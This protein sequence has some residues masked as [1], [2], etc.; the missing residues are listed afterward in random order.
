LENFWKS[1]A[2]CFLTAYLL[3]SRK[4]FIEEKGGLSE[5]K[6]E[7]FLKHG[8]LLNQFILRSQRDPGFYSYLCQKISQD[9]KTI[10][11]TKKCV[12]QLY[13]SMNDDINKNLFQIC[14]DLPPR[15]N[16]EN[17]GNNPRSGFPVLNYKKISPDLQQQMHFLHKRYDHAII[18]EDR[19]EIQ[20]IKSIVEE[21]R[22]KNCSFWTV[23]DDE[24]FYFETSSSNRRKFFSLRYLFANLLR[25]DYFKFTPHPD[26][27]FS[28]G[29]IDFTFLTQTIIPMMEELGFDNDLKKAN[30]D[31]AYLA[32]DIKKIAFII[33]FKDLNEEKKL[34]ILNDIY[35]L[36]INPAVI[37]S[38]TDLF[39]IENFFSDI[40]KLIKDGYY[41]LS[42]KYLSHVLELSRKKEDYEACFRSL[43]LLGSIEDKKN[44]WA[45][46]RDFYFDAY[47]I[48]E[49]ANRV[50][51]DDA[52]LF[53]KGYC[54]IRI[55]TATSLLGDKETSE[56]FYLKFFQNM[57]DTSLLDRVLLNKE[58]IK[59][60]H[61]TKQ[62]EK[63]YQLIKQ[64][65]DFFLKVDH[66]EFQKFEGQRKYLDQF[67]NPKKIGTFKSEEI[68]AREKS[69]EYELCFIMGMKFLLI[70]QYDLA[71]YWLNRGYEIQPNN[72]VLRRLA[73][74][75]FYRNNFPR[76]KELCEQILL[77][78]SED[79]FAFK[80]LAVVNYYSGDF[81]T[82][83]ENF[84]RA[85]NCASTN[86]ITYPF[87][88]LLLEYNQH[89]KKEN[90]YVAIQSI[91]RVFVKE[92]L[93]AK[94]NTQLLE[95][96]SDISQDTTIKIEPLVYWA[97]LGEDFSDL[98][99]LEEGLVCYKK[100]LEG[101]QF[102]DFSARVCNKIGHNLLNQDLI[103][104]GIRYFQKSTEFEPSAFFYFA[105]LADA[106]ANNLEYRSAVTNLDRAIS[107]CN[108]E[109]ETDIISNL[110]RS[111][112]QYQELA[113]TTIDF[114]KIKKDPDVFKTL[115]SAEQ[116][117]LKQ[118]K[119]I[120]KPEQFDF[121]VAIIPYAKAIE[122]LLDTHITEP[123]KLKIKSRKY[124][125]NRCGGIK[126]GYW[127]GGNLR[128][129]Y[130]SPLPYPL[131]S[132]LSSRAKKNKTM[133]LGS[134][135]NLKT[136]IYDAASNPIVKD[137]IQI[138]ENKID[139]SDF[140]KMGYAC[141]I[142]AE[143][144]NEI[145]HGKVKTWEEVIQIRKEIVEKINFII[146]LFV[147]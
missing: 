111:K 147:K 36:K 16:I 58:L 98:G 31:S 15:K 42:S 104:E 86:V 59:H 85:I 46:S 135:L 75:A 18:N 97:L 113:V 25:Y 78:D 137:F 48:L 35:P 29:F 30:V 51:V 45:R 47:E 10:W 124:I 95:I 122:I 76:V 126:D 8:G 144:R 67:R 14:P 28:L 70:F 33:W 6:I 128:K 101:S 81:K 125:F 108:P 50:R 23:F 24:E 82:S 117:V 91:V 141:N 88:D 71:E 114:S 112:T 65:S 26:D 143:Y 56:K 102:D 62:Y 80:T 132:V 37:E 116:L 20:T 34:G 21:I 57:Q 69:Q 54:Y 27:G 43:M 68:V 139:K 9:K 96:L 53:D 19:V 105:D 131:K 74:I 103:E 118:F 92:V 129:L 12:Q 110:R 66:N 41:D 106:Q 146:A 7:S 64:W 4:K 52:E 77:S 130:I 1:H 3:E 73:H 107:L 38:N 120:E 17:A 79:A 140:E 49:K 13:Y 145:A 100:A 133:A 60:F 123:F 89:D 44:E 93:I 138:V 11:L 115:F 40:K 109:T 90:P 136:E 119:K 55:C 72:E 94:N 61:F 2:Y 127:D 121:S 142:I 83:T 87:Y 39:E 22:T 84:G 134:W 63:E 32:E 99:F 5:E